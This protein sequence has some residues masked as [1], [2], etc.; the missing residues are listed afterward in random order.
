MAL[1]LFI[2]MYLNLFKRIFQKAQPAWKTKKNLA[3]TS[4][5]TT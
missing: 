5:P 3:D 2:L 1:L 4:R